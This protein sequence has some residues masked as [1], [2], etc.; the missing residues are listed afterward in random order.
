M[1]HMVANLTWRRSLPCNWVC[2][3]PS[4]LASVLHKEVLGSAWC[5]AAVLAFLLPLPHWVWL[6]LL[7]LSDLGILVFSIDGST[8]SFS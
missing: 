8:F 5:S 6:C 4:D 3:P 2:I 1:A 7:I